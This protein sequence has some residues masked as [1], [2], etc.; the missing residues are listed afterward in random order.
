M[1]RGMS[2]LDPL[3][4]IIW[5]GEFKKKNEKTL[6]QTSLFFQ[7]NLYGGLLIFCAFV[8]YDTQLIVEK[9]R[10]GDDDYIW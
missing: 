9:A 3:C 2:P 7:V 5:R 10:S 4:I 8:L 6:Q 1:H